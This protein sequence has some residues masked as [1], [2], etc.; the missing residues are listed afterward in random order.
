[1]KKFINVIT[2]LLIVVAH[3]NAQQ[4]NSNTN[5]STNAANTVSIQASMENQTAISAEQQ[6]N[7]NELVF[8]RPTK[9]IIIEDDI[10]AH[11]PFSKRVIESDILE[12][13]KPT[14]EYEDKE[15]KDVALLN[16]NFPNPF[17]HETVIQFS[18]PEDYCIAN[19]LIHDMQGKRIK[20]VSI[21][22]GDDRIYINGGELETGMYYYS[23][24]IDHK[25]IHTL[26]MIL[27][28]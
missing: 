1:M 12:S 6:A 15:V 28:H 18:L 23:L 24:E 22:S 3:L 21:N 7:S 25:I 2:F 5:W 10:Q 14:I 16:Q 9:P 19:L 11:P 27:K 26:K 8:T 13:N 17:T 20:V 4:S